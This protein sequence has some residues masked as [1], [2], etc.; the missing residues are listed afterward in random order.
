MLFFRPSEIS[1]C[2]NCNNWFQTAF[3]IYLF[4]PRQHLTVVFQFAFSRFKSRQVA[5]LRCLAAFRLPIRNHAAAE[6]GGAHELAAMH[7]L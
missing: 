5:A 4:P 7:L 3:V 1:Y 6:V 2:K